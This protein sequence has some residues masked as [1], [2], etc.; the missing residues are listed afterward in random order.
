[1]KTKEF[2]F[3]VAVLQIQ[4]KI[5]SANWAN[6]KGHKHAKRSPLTK[7]EAQIIYDI[8]SERAPQCSQFNGSK[9]NW[10]SVAPTEIILELRSMLKNLHDITI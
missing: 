9:Y 1:M 6:L 7:S 5:K 10:Y 2:C 3:S 4:D 8:T